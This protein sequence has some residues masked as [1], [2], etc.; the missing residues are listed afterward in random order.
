MI[1]LADDNFEI[2]T[3]VAYDGHPEHG[4]FNIRK[5]D[6]Q[7]FQ[8]GDVI[9][10]IIDLTS[11]LEGVNIT[12]HEI[13]YHRSHYGLEDSMINGPGGDDG[14]RSIVMDKIR[15]VEEV[16]IDSIEVYFIF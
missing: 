5:N 11:H 13:H 9:D 8:I 6:S 12:I 4:S 3:D 2:S 15:T 7:E 1:D 14:W 10:A 16:Y